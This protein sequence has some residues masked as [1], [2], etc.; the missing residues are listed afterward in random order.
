MVSLRASLAPALVEFESA[1][2]TFLE[3]GVLVSF[4]VSFGLDV[5]MMDSISV[6]DDEEED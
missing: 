4:P 1:N 3:E 5:F 2:L 6:L